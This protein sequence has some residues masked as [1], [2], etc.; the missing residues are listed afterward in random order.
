[1]K[2]IPLTQGK[3]AL[4][5]DEYFEE[6]S[7]YKWFYAQGYAKTNYFI[8]GLRRSLPMHRYIL[9]TPKGMET[10]HIN[11]NKLDNRKINLRIA[12]TKQNSQNKKPK[13]HSSIY[14]GVFWEKETNKWRS[15]IQVNKKQISLGR[16][17]NELEA[18]KVYNE[19]AIK[20]F[21]EFAYLNK[22]QGETND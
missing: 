5:D 20:Y 17:E 16:F 19:N 11:L 6:L 22:I 18:V 2:E 1:M 8:N 13:K 14:K 12:T 10:D 21:G 7:K 3:V 9:K 4:V 15:L